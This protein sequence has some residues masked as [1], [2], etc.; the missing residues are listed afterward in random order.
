[1]SFPDAKNT[2]FKID[3][4]QF[5]FPKNN[6]QNIFQIS[7]TAQDF[8]HATYFCVDIYYN[9]DTGKM[10]TT[11]NV[12]ASLLTSLM[13]ADA[14]HQC[15]TDAD[16]AD[17]CSFCMN[18]PSKHAPYYCHAKEK[19]CC[20]SDKDCPG[21]YCMNS[22][23]KKKPF[24]CHG[25]LNEAVE[26]VKEDTIGYPVYCKT[27]GYCHVPGLPTSCTNN[28]ECQTPWY[29]SS[30]CQSG[31]SCHLE[32]PPKCKKDS[33]CNPKSL[34]VPAKK[35]GGCTTDAQCP[36]S[37]CQ[38]HF[39]CHLCG[40]ACCLT[41]AD[42]AGSYCVNDPTKT[43]PYFCH[44]T[45]LNTLV[46]PTPKQ[47]PFTVTKDPG[48]FTLTS[49]AM[50]TATGKFTTGTVATVNVKGIVNKK[51]ISGTVK[52]QI[53][54]TGVTSFIASGN[55]PYFDCTHK[56]CDLNKPLALTLTDKTGKF[57]TPYSLQFNFALPKLK[58]SSKQFRIVLWGSDQDHFPYDFSATITYNSR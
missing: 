16:C 13:T 48:N 17:E 5:P 21:S 55:S 3:G 51:L 19:G 39:E 49:I 57:P 22:P 2:T 20:D 15:T 32:P 45:L 33:D 24:Y 53:Y 31:G 41:D 25:L 46:L 52:Y 6:G 27:N 47:D 26:L 56:G 8:T 9:L 50:S 38:N 35:V 30:Y 18:D 42:C 28:K 36:S 12:E 7:F 4:V 29:P 43:P 23:G 14:P 37:Y 10:T 58:S 40:D 44:A 34:T 11:K 1:M 54:E